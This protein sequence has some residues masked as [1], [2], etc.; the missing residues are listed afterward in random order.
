MGK[1]V[2]TDEV[3]ESSNDY[4]LGEQ[5]V[6]P[7]KLRISFS[8][9]KTISS[10]KLRNSIQG[11]H[12]NIRKFEVKVREPNSTLWVPFII[13]GYPQ[14]PKGL[15]P[16]PLETFNGTAITA[17]EVEFSCLNAFAN[18]HTNKRCALNYLTYA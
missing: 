18:G 8:C 14:N 2:L 10:L 13:D 4:W 12:Q 11:N 9:P 16:A 15:N 6:F 7:Q 17:I 1:N 3:P 5:N